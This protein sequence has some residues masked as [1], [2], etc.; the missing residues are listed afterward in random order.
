MAKEDEGEYKCAVEC[1]HG[2]FGIYPKVFVTDKEDALRNALQTE[3]PLA[4]NLLCIWHIN[5]IILKNVLNQF[6]CRDSF[7]CFM[8]DWN[9][10]L[11]CLTEDSFNDSLGE[12]REKYLSN[13]GAL[14]YLNNNVFPLKQYIAKPWTSQVQHLGNTATSHAEGQHRM[15]KDYFD[16]SVGDILTVVN[17][18]HLSCSNQYHE[19][20][21]KIAAEK[22]QYYIQFDAFYDN[23]R[24]KISSFALDLI[25]TQLSLPQPLKTC[26]GNFTCVYGIPC[27]HILQQKLLSHIL[28]ERE[29]FIQ[30][31]WLDDALNNE[32]G[33]SFEAELHRVQALA[34]AGGNAANSLMVQLRCVGNPI[35]VT[36]PVVPRTKGRPRGA[37]NKKGR[38][39][40]AFEHVEGNISGRR[41][42]TCGRVGH[43]SRTCT[44]NR[45]HDG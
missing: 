15:V 24:G 16:S 33:N 40:S 38:E 6:K 14:E 12:L 19:F 7:D 22:I 45:L 41:C 8:R 5:K 23:V 4:V 30:Q 28:L 35:G 3:F 27:T 10:V 21:T 2:C 43:N 44:R 29:D 9:A 11:N 18:L 34:E 39:P 32:N 26:S 31:W 42:K 37:K 17:N 20:K 1:F 25:N 36:N 13:E